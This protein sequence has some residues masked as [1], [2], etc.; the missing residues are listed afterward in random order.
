[1]FTVQETIL[2]SDNQEIK[3]E[4]AR[5][6]TPIEQL[7]PCQGLCTG[8]DVIDD[9]LFWRGLPKGDLSLLLGQPGSGTTTLWLKAARQAH[10]RLGRSAWVSAPSSQAS[11]VTQI[12][13]T[14]AD[15][16]EFFL[17]QMEIELQKFL[18]AP[19]EQEA[20]RTY[21][22]VK[23]LIESEQFELIGCPLPQTQIRQLQDLKIMARHFDVSLVFFSQ[24]QNPLLNPFFGLVMECQKDFHTIHKAMHRP[25]P[26]SISSEM[27]F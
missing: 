27:V 16:P 19:G 22:L 25:T 2:E 15:E 4:L 23:E 1:M 12:F 17:A 7:R 14:H 6:L 8:V 26:F 13:P 20:A 18:L 5:I 3:Q 24:V 10:L 11:S 9:F 21:L